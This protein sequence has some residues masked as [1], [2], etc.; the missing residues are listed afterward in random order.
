MIVINDFFHQSGTD[1]EGD[2]AVHL[3]F[4]YL[5]IAHKADVI[6]ADVAHDFRRAGLLIDLHHGY[7]GTKGKIEVWRV[8]IG[9]YFQSWLHAS[10]N[11]PGKPQSGSN[12]LQCFRAAWIG[13]HLNF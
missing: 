1:P 13:V 11:V 5:R 3:P 8:E 6:Y 4:Y 12:V 2:A 10:R 7:M 9:G